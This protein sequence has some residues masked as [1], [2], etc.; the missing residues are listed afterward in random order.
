[1]WP[2]PR[3]SLVE[4]EMAEWMLDHAEWLLV[5]H[6]RR[7]A[8]AAAQLIP[9][10]EKMFPPDGLE[11]H[12]LAEHMLDHVLRHMGLS[13][14]RISLVPDDEASRFADT[15][16]RYRPQWRSTASGTYS[17]H[18]SEISYDVELL[19]RPIDLVAVLAH[20]VSHAVLDLGANR[21]PPSDPDFDELLT[22]FTAVLLGFGLFQ[23]GFR[24][25][26]RV[27]SVEDA[28]AARDAYA[29]YMSRSE[30]CTATALFASI[31]G[32]TPNLLLRAADEVDARGSLKH[33]VKD[34]G[35]HRERVGELREMVAEAKRG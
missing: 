5:A 2:F 22:D 20:E 32:I 19:K 31:H 11:G 14:L 28:D 10:S 23:I 12:A 8:F 1:M 30:A 9:I 25:P 27:A 21:E 6:A 34:M 24:K 29:F 7:R 13:D 33:A 35:E 26:V 17:G 18:L 15:G 16:N 4:P 3:K